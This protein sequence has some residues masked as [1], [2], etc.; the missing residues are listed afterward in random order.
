VIGIKFLREKR[1]QE[2]NMPAIRFVQA[3]LQDAAK[4]SAGEIDIVFPPARSRPNLPT[5]GAMLIIGNDET[6]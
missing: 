4:R 1:P 3:C 5:C 2:A 6:K